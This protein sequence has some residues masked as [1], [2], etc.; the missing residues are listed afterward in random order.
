MNIIRML[1]GGFMKIFSNDLIH[2]GKMDFTKW[3]TANGDYVNIKDV[4]DA[5]LERSMDTLER[6]I[7]KYPNHANQHVWQRYIQA[8]ENEVTN[9]EGSNDKKKA[10]TK[11]RE[12]LYQTAGFI[13]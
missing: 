5:Y 2:E 1:G 13:G 7:E 8:F 4:G 11:K 10:L 6:Y 12:S 9:R 3:E